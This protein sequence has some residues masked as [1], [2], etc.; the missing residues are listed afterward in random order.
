MEL[1]KLNKALI[2]AFGDLLEILM[3]YPTKMVPETPETSIY[4]HV[5]QKLIPLTTETTIVETAFIEKPAWELQTQQIQLIFIN[6]QYIL[7]S[8]YRP[9][10]ARYQIFDILQSQIH[11]KHELLRDFEAISKSIQIGVPNASSLMIREENLIEMSSISSTT[12]ISISNLKRK[13]D[14]LQSLTNPQG[15]NRTPPQSHDDIVMEEFQK[16]LKEFI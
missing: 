12:N 10:Q 13:F 4:V 9:I 16:T 8:F 5:P 14:D 1:K 15:Q 6:L 3:K 7:N 11:K 2:E